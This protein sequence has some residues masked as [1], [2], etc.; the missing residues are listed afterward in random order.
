VKFG[1]GLPSPA[2]GDAGKLMADMVSRVVDAVDRGAIPSGQY[3][4]ILIDEGHDFEPEWLKL[5]VRMVGEETNSL[6]LLYDDA[7]STY[8]GSE[9]RSF[10]KG[11]KR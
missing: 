10:Q 7:Q 8:V 3:S 9:K 1:E 6:L 2:R 11:D 5:I 4:A